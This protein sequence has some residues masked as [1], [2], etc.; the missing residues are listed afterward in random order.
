[1]IPLR[2]IATALAL[3]FGLLQSGHAMAGTTVQVSLWD[4]GD[5]AM[6]MLDKAKP[7]AMGMMR[8]MMMSGDMK[9][10][11]MGITASLAEVPAGEVTFTVTNDSKGMIH[12]MILSPVKDETASLPYVIDEMRVDE[13][14]AGHL[15]E[16]A[17]LDPGKSGT[18]T[19]NLEPGNYLLFCNIPGHYA[20][21]MWTL[22]T[23][24][25]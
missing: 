20:L 17:E 2:K 6:D 25:P 12:E 23:V 21:G 7:M 1:M 15:G 24:T 10:G 18:L 19:L 14:A 13:E 11:A 4:N 8:Q 16:V 9:M 3:T 22:V 5:H